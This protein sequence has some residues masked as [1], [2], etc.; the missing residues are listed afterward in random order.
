M[1]V[2]SRVTPADPQF[3][4]TR[5]PLGVGLTGLLRGQTCGQQPESGEPPR[6]TQPPRLRRHGQEGM[7]DKLTTETDAKH[8]DDVWTPDFRGLIMPIYLYSPD[9]WFLFLYLGFFARL[10]TKANVNNKISILCSQTGQPSHTLT[11]PPFHSPVFLEP[12]PSPSLNRALNST[13]FCPRDLLAR[14]DPSPQPDLLF[15][16]GTRTEWCLLDLV[17]LASSV[18]CSRP[19]CPVNHQPSP[20]PRGNLCDAFSQQP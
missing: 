8:L 17:L 18:F 2:F 13:S 5:L 12:P 6:D 7:M 16:P 11:F 20:L 10:R 19:P 14:L 1:Q 4:A 15:R 9:R 3:V